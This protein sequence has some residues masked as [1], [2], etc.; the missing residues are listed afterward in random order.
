MQHATDATQRYICHARC[1]DYIRPSS[2]QYSNEGALNLKLMGQSADHEFDVN[3]NEVR[4]SHATG[5]Q[6]RE[7]GEEEEMAYGGGTATLIQ[8]EV[9]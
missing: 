6:W 3:L 9:C 4:H 7:R 8:R 5:G 1:N 2:I